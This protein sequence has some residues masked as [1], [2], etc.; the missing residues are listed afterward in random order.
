MKTIR[1]LF[2]M[3]FVFGL[4]V[5]GC[6][7]KESDKAGPSARTSEQAAK[8]G[9]AFLA[10]NQSQDGSFGKSPDVGFT[11]LAVY[12]VAAGP[13]ASG[14]DAK[15]MV[16]RGAE[17]L[18]KNLREDGSIN[19]DKQM[20][21]IYRTAL[22]VMALNAVDANAYADAIEKAQ[23]YLVRAQFSEAN[24][25][26]T[27]QN[28]EFGGWGY[29]S[30]PETMGKVAPD[31]SNAQFALNALKESGLTEDDEAYKR[32]IVFLS[33]CQNRSESNDMGSTD[34]GGGF[35]APK[36]SKAGVVTLPD[37]RTVYKSYGSMT[38]ALLKGFVFCG[39]KKDDARV[40]A[41]FDWIS[42]N[43]TVDE[44]PG[45]GQ[46]GL[47]YYFMTMA[48]TLGELDVD[49]IETEDGRKHDWRAELS[50][51]ILGLQ[52]KD[53]SWTNTQDRWMES[54]PVLVTGYALTALGYC[55]K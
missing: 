47:F 7:K 15:R 32:A 17:F 14:P 41:A 23:D 55:R 26:F 25:D 34:D 43:Y 45:V 8:D 33:R 9:I 37:G 27:A 40:K 51:K 46:M 24:G 38:Y 31:L 1:L 29:S 50:A 5:G 36:E 19:Q 12:S 22:A 35:Y 48:R 42:K 10:K 20:L 39:L 16:Q 30:K 44:N 18:V 4:A 21:S 13:Y 52:N 2:V 53:G 6:G 28:W 49:T 11:G 54:D 3:A